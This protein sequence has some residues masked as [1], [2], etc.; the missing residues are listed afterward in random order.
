[1]LWIAIWTLTN[2]LYPDLETMVTGDISTAPTISSPTSPTQAYR[3]FNF[4]DT[5]LVRYYGTTGWERGN[6]C[7]STSV[8]YLEKYTLI[9][10]WE[11]FTWSSGKGLTW[12]R[13]SLCKELLKR[14]RG[15]NW[16]SPGQTWCDRLDL[17]EKQLSIDSGNEWRSKDSVR[18]NFEF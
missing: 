16:R 12:S 11:N 4:A 5:P 3:Q 6:G 18:N 14:K 15:S 8:E 13:V 9:L 17:D 10:L 1:M 7:I 2:T